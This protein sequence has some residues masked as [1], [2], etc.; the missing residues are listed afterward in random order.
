[1]DGDEYLEVQSEGDHTSILILA[2]DRDEDHGSDEDVVADDTPRGTSFLSRFAG[3]PHLFKGSKN[4]VT[5]S[6]ETE[7]VLKTAIDRC[8]ECTP[9]MT[10]SCRGLGVQPCTACQRHHTCWSRLPCVG[11]TRPEA[12]R[13]TAHH[14]FK[15]EAYEQGLLQVAAQE[16][17]ALDRDRNPSR[18][19]PF[20]E[21]Q[22][23]PFHDVA[24][25]TVTTCAAPTSLT[26]TTCAASTAPSTLQDHQAGSVR[27]PGVGAVSTS[28]VTALPAPKLS[29]TGLPRRSTSLSS[30]LF[31]P[32]QG[33]LPPLASLIIPGGRA[34]RPRHTD[35]QMNTA[36]RD[37]ADVIVDG[38]TG[39]DRRSDLQRVEH[40]ETLGLADS[41]LQGQEALAQILGP[42]SGLHDASDSTQRMRERL[43]AL[44]GG[45][46]V[47]VQEFPGKE[48][49]RP[50]GVV[51]APVRAGARHPLGEL[52]LAGEGG[53]M[54]WTDEEQQAL[55][56]EQLSNQLY[57]DLGEARAVNM[58]QGER[59]RE[60]EEELEGARARG[61]SYFQTW[62]D[63]HP[64]PQQW[65][66]GVPYNPSNLEVY[67]E[68]LARG[69]VAQP[70]SNPHLEQPGGETQD[71]P[72]LT[73]DGLGLQ[74]SQIQ[75]NPALGELGV[76][77]GLFTP[78]TPRLQETPPG[79][80][81]RF[82][83]PRAST[84]REDG[85]SA[86]WA[87]GGFNASSQTNSGRAGGGFNA[88]SQTNSGRAGGGFNAHPQ[89]ASGGAGGGGGGPDP[90]GG[91]HRRPAG[92]GR[93]PPGP[94]GGPP[95]PSGQ[96]GPGCPD[97]EGN[98]D[99]LR[100]TLLQLAGS[101]QYMAANQG[102][103]HHGS[104]VRAPA[105]R[106][107][108]MIASPDGT[109]SAIGYH[110][111]KDQLVNMITDLRINEPI[112]INI[113]QNDPNI[114]PH[115]YRS[116]LGFCHTLEQI[117]NRLEQ[118]FPHKETT[119]YKLKEALFRPACQDN[120]QAIVS[121][122]DELIAN[123]ELLVRVHPLNRLTRVEA[124]AT[125]AGIG[126][127][128]VTGGI[129]SIVERFDQRHAEGVT[130]EG[131]LHEYL[132]RT[133]KTRLDLICAGQL[134]RKEAPTTVHLL[135]AP[136]ATGRGSGER[137]NSSAA[138]SAKEVIEASSKRI[139]DTLCSACPVCND[140]HTIWFCPNL[141]LVK[142]GKKP[143]PVDLC[144]LCLKS[145]V[146]GHPVNCF[147]YRRKDGKKG[148]C[149]CVRDGHPKI[150]WKIC[151][152]CPPAKTKSLLVRLTNNQH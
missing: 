107:N 70:L 25:L 95:D 3:S 141:H 13:Y 8:G 74:L 119:L 125:L 69:A 92:E 1:M 38:A 137:N 36:A 88:S 101:M 127:A 114:I 89:T 99:E 41:D 108:R 9:C 129:T 75:D 48:N 83:N 100:D 63:E 147:E 71:L 44:R 76:D 12:A 80:G 54:D 106:F 91:P 130:Y 30:H 132:S 138:P 113:L 60:V 23:Q 58:R 81:V 136:A 61:A 19:L 112:V 143:L 66:S 14:K 105:V 26:V 21:V 98:S 145:K 126:G 6:S 140:R 17:E 118:V 104:Q 68:I 55:F 59:I 72:S 97:S 82:Q 29:M 134:C 32:F 27:T 4:K 135:A 20:G 40:W 39:L 53:V 77:L 51:L 50:D 94:P 149:L 64:R 2:A 62:T 148:S 37:T 34:S 128:E 18:T 139:G 47:R 45:P 52:R 90:P 124:L 96:G 11:W 22:F 103:H 133:R 31:R 87:E 151:S 65:P 10:K 43:S 116:Q 93:G 102:Q 28:L 15:R 121:R 142:T 152:K 5:P 79:R 78:I 49:Q 110:T 42:L 85:G 86:R 57:A 35:P 144:D 122:C 120:S 131:L 7:A 33:A 56:G 67:Q 115:K 73:P 24:A 123:L 146:T 111:W 16:Q 150:H 117:F 84:P 46:S 109:V